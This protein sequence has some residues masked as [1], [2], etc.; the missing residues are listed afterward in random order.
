MTTK[1]FEGDRVVVSDTFFWAKG[2]SGTVGKPPDPIVTLSGPWTDGLTRIERS[3]LG[4]NEVYFVYFD[5]PQFD[6]DGDGPY[7]GGQVWTSALALL[8]E[9]ST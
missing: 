4:E 7:R 6:A 5:E 1:F 8:S 9:I 3:A 2:A